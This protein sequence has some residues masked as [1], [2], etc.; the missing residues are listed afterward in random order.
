LLTLG[1]PACGDYNGGVRRSDTGTTTTR[2]RR[3]AVAC[4]AGA[5]ALG[6]FAGVAVVFLFSVSVVRTRHAIV[7]EVDSYGY[8]LAG[9][10]IAAGEWPRWADDFG[11]FRGHVWVD[12]GDGRTMAKY[13]PGWPA[14]LAIG[15]R[16]DGLDGALRVN[17][18][19]AVVG[20]AAFFLL[21]LLLFGPAGATAC[22]AL[23]LFSPILAFYVAYPL[24][25]SADVTFVLLTMLL[26]AAWGRWGWTVF[27]LLAGACAGFLPA[28]RPTSV[29]VWPAA[30]LLAAAVRHEVWRR[31]IEGHLPVSENTRRGRFSGSASGRDPGFKNG[32]AQA[33][34]P[35]RI[36]IPFRS[37]TARWIALPFRRA[38]RDT[39]SRA[40]RR[41]LRRNRGAVA[42]LAGAAVTLLPLLVYNT[43]S[44]GL[45][46][47][48]GY[49]LTGEQSAFD[50]ADWRE[51]L[52]QL[53]D[54]RPVL[55]GGAAWALG[56]AGVALRIGGSGIAWALALWF[57]PTVALYLGYYW[58]H[59]PSPAF[60]RFLLSAAPAWVLMAGFLFRPAM[61]CGWP[62]VRV[63]L[64]AVAVGLAWVTVRDA[65]PYR[66]VP[67]ID[68]TSWAALSRAVREPFAGAS[69][70]PQWVSTLRALAARRPVAA[71]ATG[72]ELWT[73]GALPNVTGYDLSAWTDCH[74]ARPAG[75]DCATDHRILVDPRRHRRLH[76][77]VAALAATGGLPADF[78][79]RLDRLTRDG[80]AVVLIGRRA[81]PC[82]DAPKCVSICGRSPLPAKF[83]STLLL[84]KPPL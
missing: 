81:T 34:P 21:A 13:P 55:L 83:R 72:T 64:V 52:S 38:L 24:S 30:L 47:R 18:V 16:A 77:R 32:V 75:P 49:G 33:T 70:S 31:R 20:A 54:N 43:V 56:L 79:R 26:A 27:A 9:R 44:F 66:D 78:D 68:V 15:Y 62:A 14:L 40:F 57:V 11:R 5:A 2:R 35:R 80:V 37:S 71:L 50:F 10:S 22:T 8:L 74:Y 17:T 53:F 29:L 48:T 60:Y 1:A 59:G 76:E 19:V 4:D 6:V 84:P 45:P 25:H 3:L 42:L 36:F 61:R 51:R 69:S 63:G 7:P 73:A 28:V 82:F 39:R 23:W 67:K 65:V 58:W 12:A 46:W 41:L